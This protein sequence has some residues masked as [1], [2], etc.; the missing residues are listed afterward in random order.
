[1]SSR[2]LRRAKQH[3]LNTGLSNNTPVVPVILGNSVH[4]LELSRRLFARGINVQPILYPAVEER[5]ARL[6]FFITACHTPSQIDS[7]VDAV[8]EE[9]AEMR[10][11]VGR[12]Y[13]DPPRPPSMPAPLGDTSRRGF[14]RGFVGGFV[15]G[16][17]S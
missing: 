9:L 15:R 4:A 12:P 6:R 17:L 11:D 16:Q 13:R 5:A 7:A 8:A 14:V 3:G 10:R 1:M 2:F